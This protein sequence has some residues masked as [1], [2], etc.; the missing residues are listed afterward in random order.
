MDQSGIDD[1]HSMLD[2]LNGDELTETLTHILARLRLSE[3][4]VNWPSDPGKH[5][6][7]DSHLNLDTVYKFVV[8]SAKVCYRR[9]T[10][11]KC[12]L[13]SIFH[14]ELADPNGLLKPAMKL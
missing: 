13:K 12:H 14:V 11:L 4:K 7:L 6:T 9:F 1:G 5:S 3:S 10:R 2:K 8:H